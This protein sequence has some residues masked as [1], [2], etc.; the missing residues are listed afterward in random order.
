MG[1]ITVEE[2]QVWCERTKLDLGAQLD[3]GLEEQVSS[4][5]LGRVATIYDTSSWVSSLTTPKLIKTIIAMYYT[6]WMYNKLYSD[7]NDDTNGYADKLMSMA[8]TLLQNIMEGLTVIPGV[9][10]TDDPSEPSFYPTDASSALEATV[11][12]PSLGPAKFSMGTIF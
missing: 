8:D 2:A 7:D 12:D 9:T 3:G 4:Q 1:N 10:P 11:E 6:A 5:I